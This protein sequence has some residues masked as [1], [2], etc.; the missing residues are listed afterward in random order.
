MN[1]HDIHTFS[2]VYNIKKRNNKVKNTTQ[3]KQ[4]IELNIL[5]QTWINEHISVQN[6]V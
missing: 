5:Q 6:Y 1:E 2:T 3:W 4:I